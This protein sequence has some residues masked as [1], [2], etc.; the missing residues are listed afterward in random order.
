[1]GIKVK[2]VAVIGFS[3]VMAALV[4]GDF[5]DGALGLAATLCVSVFAAIIFLYLYVTVMSFIVDVS[6]KGDGQ[7]RSRG[8]HREGP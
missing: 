7:S 6:R 5:P 4:R 8:S 2:I 3:A 1:M